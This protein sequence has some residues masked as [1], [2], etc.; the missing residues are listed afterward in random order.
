VANWSADFLERNPDLAGKTLTRHRH[1]ITAALN[2]SESVTHFVGCPAHYQDG[3]GAWQPLDTALQLIGTEYGAPGLATRIG[4]DGAVRIAGQSHSHRST[5][6]GILTPATMSFVGYRTIPLGHVSGNQIIAENGIWQRVLTLTERGLREEIVIAEKPAIPG[7]KLGD[8]LV[9]ETAITGSS[10]PDGWL[11]AFEASEMRFPPPRAHDSR[12]G[13]GSRAEC[14]RYARTVGNIQYL[15]TGVPVS[16]LADAVYPVT[17]DPDYAAGS[18]D[19]VIYGADPTYATARSTSY[20]YNDTLEYGLVGQITSIQVYRVLLVFSTS[21]I[22]DT[23]VI[24]QVN[25]KATCI[26]NVSDTDFDVQIVKQDWSAQNPVGAANQ[27]AAYDN[28][29]SATADAN[30]WR[31][32]SGISENTQYTSGNLATDWPSKTGNTYYSLRSSRDKAGTEPSGN[33]Y[34]SIGTQDNATSGYRPLLAITHAAG[35][36]PAMLRGTS[37]PGLRQWQP[38]GPGRWFRRLGADWTQRRGGL[39]APTGV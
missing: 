14:K 23:D 7:V 5:R 27:E 3:N 38:S 30:I 28:C 12:V 29:L 17:I 24:S 19:V 6:V 39:L 36:H 18:A 8:W 32:T 25:L 31:G 34:I 20:G 15:Y 33:E 11:D 9:L 37:V 2:A 10:F 4:L 35:G 22:P 1:G 21:A 16:W 26:T 13:P